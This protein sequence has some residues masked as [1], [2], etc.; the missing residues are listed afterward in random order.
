[1]SRPLEAGLRS[2]EHA[3][4]SCAT[5]PAPHIAAF[6]GFIRAIRSLGRR[7]TEDGVPSGVPLFGII[8][9]SPNGFPWTNYMRFTG[10]AKDSQAHFSER[11]RA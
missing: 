4:K 3:W 2:S 11:G 9:G 1:M 5:T 10:A 8:F 7:G 6:I